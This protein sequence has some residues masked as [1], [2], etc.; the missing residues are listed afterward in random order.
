MAG[1]EDAGW[2]VKRTC[3]TCKR[4]FV[5]REARQRLGA[6]I[7]WAASRIGDL[8]H[9]IKNLQALVQN[10]SGGLQKLADTLR[11][12]RLAQPGVDMTAKK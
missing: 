3:P 7:R 11:L 8:E 5:A 9:E 1:V 12:D 2:Q 4:R 10:L 6:E